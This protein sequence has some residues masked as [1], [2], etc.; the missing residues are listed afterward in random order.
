MAPVVENSPLRLA[1]RGRACPA[2]SGV[3]RLWLEDG[4]Q[5]ANLQHRAEG[6]AD[7][8]LKG[9]AVGMRQRLIDPCSLTMREFFANTTPPPEPRSTE[10]LIDRVSRK[11]WAEASA[12]ELH[13]FVIGTSGGPQRSRSVPQTA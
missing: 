5:E 10:A 1:G 8:F 6:R 7:D 12:P 4:Y 2:I 11:A 9:L 3:D 13:D